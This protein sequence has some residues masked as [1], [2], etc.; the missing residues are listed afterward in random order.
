MKVKED[1]ENSKLKA[2]HRVKELELEKQKVMAGNL[3]ISSRIKSK[4][5]EECLRDVEQ[6]IEQAQKEEAELTHICDIS[7]VLLGYIEIDKFKK[8]R[9]QTYYDNLKH[10]AKFEHDYAKSQHEL[11]QAILNSESVQRVEK[12]T[13][14][15]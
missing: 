14:S 10:L 11:W 9:Q 7:T 8:L 15:D 13:R 1:Y 2:V 6:E 3:S 4:S 5:K 12:D